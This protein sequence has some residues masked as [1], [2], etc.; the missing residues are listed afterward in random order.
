MAK[1]VKKTSTSKLSTTKVKNSGKLA[2]FKRLGR[3]QQRSLVVLL[4]ALVGVGGFLTYRSFAGSYTYVWGT[5]SLKQVGTYAQ[6]KTEPTG[7]GNTKRNI[8]YLEI[9]SPS[10]GAYPYTAVLVDSRSTALY[11]N[12]LINYA[13]SSVKKLWVRT[14]ANMKVVSTNRSRV[15]LLPGVYKWINGKNV[16]LLDYTI[17]LSKTV[18]YKQYCAVVT[19]DLSG[20][21]DQLSKNDWI[22]IAEPSVGF[23]FTSGPGEVHVASISI[24]LSDVPL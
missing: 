11:R 6:T 3:M 9:K 16:P 1:T 10:G 7:S 20:L 19:D 2:W 14:C 24:T 12:Q 21:R 5:S 15:G 22:N 23:N 8:S 17:T 18:D 13:K 4:V